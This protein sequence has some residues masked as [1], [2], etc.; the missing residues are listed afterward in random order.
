LGHKEQNLISKKALKGCIKVL[1]PPANVKPA[2]VSHHKCKDEAREEWMMQM[3]LSPRAVYV[4]RGDGEK[5]FTCCSECK[6][7]L[8]IGC[9]LKKVPRFAI[10]NGFHIGEAP[11]ELEDLNEAELALVSIARVNSHIFTF[12]GGAHKSIRGWHTLYD[13]NVGHMASTLQQFPGL[14]INNNISCVLCGPFTTGQFLKIK[15]RMFVNCEKVIAAL[16][17]LQKNNVLYEDAVIPNKED[18]PQPIIIDNNEARDESEDALIENRID[19]TIQFPDPSEPTETHG[20]LGSADELEKTMMELHSNPLTDFEL[21]ARPSSKMLRDH[22]GTNLLKAFPLQFP[23]GHGAFSKLHN[24]NM[25][26]ATYADHVHHLSL[27][28]MHKADFNLILHNMFE[29]DRVLRSGVWQCNKHFGL[30]DPSVGDCFAAMTT[31]ELTSAV[32]HV[33]NG[34]VA[35]LGVGSMFLRTINACCKSMC[36]SNEASK[37]ARQRMFSMINMFGLP[38]VFFMVTPDDSNIF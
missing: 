23:Y 7:S 4:E 22:L 32:N 10:A 38:A 31:R 17:W 35:G 1:K 27:P 8:S 28:N 18:T 3:M 19:V 30:N 26:F 6:T 29:R 37:E 9:R 36:H 25:S 13:G 33:H 24:K 5:G 2:V 12:Y 14:N 34:V 20:G 21:H 11:K 15:E 16:E